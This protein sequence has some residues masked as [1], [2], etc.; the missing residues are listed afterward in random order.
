MSSVFELTDEDLEKYLEEVEDED[1]EEFEIPVLKKKSP[2][3]D[4]TQQKST[5][6]TNE[7]KQ[8]EKYEK[9][10]KQKEQKEKESLTEL[11][12]KINR[13][14]N[15]P[16]EEEGGAENEPVEEEEV[17]KSQT[18]TWNEFL[19]RNVPD[20]SM[21]ELEIASKLM[22]KIREQDIMDILD[23]LRLP[24]VPFQEKITIINKTIKNPQELFI[25][26][27]LL[28]KERDAEKVEL[29]ALT[30]KQDVT[31]GYYVCKRCGSNKTMA[32]QKQTRSADEPMTEFVTCQSCGLKWRIG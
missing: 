32:R 10:Q 18:K 27:P 30:E 17:K 13:K 7:K 11:A 1:Q 5:E 28:K 16:K 31:E 12:K 26:H 8:R 23:I 25:N 6:N 4:S 24:E 22:E 20:L 14:V 19:E 29:R 2:K 9:K 3:R 15:K 21:K